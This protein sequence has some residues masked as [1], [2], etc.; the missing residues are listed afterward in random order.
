MADTFEQLTPR[1]AAFKA[2]IKT[3]Y[4]LLNQ[5]SQS[6]NLKYEEVYAD[7][8][9]GYRSKRGLINGV[10]S[11][12]KAISGNLDSSDGEYFNECI[13]KIS[14]DESEL[15]N[16]MKNQITVTTSVIKSFNSTIQKLQIDEATFNE[17]IK[18]IEKTIYDITDNLSFIGAKLKTLELCESLMESYIFL[19]ATLDDILNSITFAR[20]RII[21]TS[22]ITP[23]DLVNSLQDISHSLR[24]NNLPLPVTITT[25][26]SYLDLIELEAYQTESKVVFVLRIPL[27]DPETYTLY[28]LSPIPIPD[29]RT[30]LYHMLQTS[31][32][33]IAKDDDSLLY[34]PLRNLDPC[35]NIEPHVKLCTGILPT[36][37][38]NTAICEAQ[39]LRHPMEVP[40]SCQSSIILAENYNVQELATNLWLIAISKPV[41]IT[42]KCVD[43]E[44]ASTIIKVNS[45]LK[46]QPG[47][48]AFVG[49][50]RIHSKSLA[51]N[52]KSVTYKTQA[53]EVP[54][55]CCA[56]I[57]SKKE[58][59]H[60][61]PLKLNKLDTEDLN[62]ANHKLSQYSEEL[63]RMMKQPFVSKHISWF[64]YLTIAAIIAL[65]ILYI[66][67]KCRRRRSARISIMAPSPPGPPG[68][69][70]A[71]FKNPFAPRL[72]PRRRPS[73]QNEELQESVELCP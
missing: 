20:L 40:E 44:P 43:Q 2:E 35:K 45:L 61:K 47:C 73:A 1:M 72:F 8:K 59:L 53:I 4:S 60:L 56:H 9:L 64:T 14:R 46:L 69:P 21:H 38:D 19:E 28:R 54:Y 34:I 52:H 23:K 3:H 51:S 26:S 29:K 30:G 67:C 37:L 42:V 68:P 25:V 65:V 6:L 31:Q 18:D 39:L 49:S 15:E 33:Y 58:A 70:G 71:K 11:F 22:I 62:I 10:G 13:D 32:K 12:W 7:T 41:P 24:K 16:L 66:F 5:I 50:T 55:E 57:P 36:P 17:D 27:I 63:D 48:G